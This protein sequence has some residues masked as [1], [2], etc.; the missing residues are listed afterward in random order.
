MRSAHT[1]CH[2]SLRHWVEC[3]APRPAIERAVANDAC[4][5]PT[6]CNRHLAAH[7]LQRYHRTAVG[8]HCTQGS[9]QRLG[10]EAFRVA[11]ALLL[12]VLTFAS[13][14]G[15]R[16]SEELV[17][18]RVGNRL[19]EAVLVVE[20]EGR[21]WLPLADVSSTLSVR[22]VSAQDRPLHLATPLGIV[23]VPARYLVQTGDVAYIDTHFLRDRLSAAVSLDPDDLLITVELPWRAGAPV[24]VAEDR[25]P[26]LRLEPEARPPRA[27]LSTLH[28]DLAYTFRKR[29]RNRFE[30]LFRASG[31]A[32]GGV[33]R[34][35]YE[36]DIY[37][38]RRLRD[39]VWMT[40]FGEGR[41]LQFGHQTIAQ[42][43]LMQTVELTGAQVAWTNV[44]A[45]L[46]NRSLYAGAL[47][48][49]TVE[50][51][52]TFEGRGPVGGFAQLWLNDQ[53]IAQTPIGIDGAYRFT[54]VILPV[55]QS[56]VQIR[57]Y[58]HRSAVTPVDIISK[59]L[60]LSD[61]LLQPGQMSVSG[62]VGHGRNTFEDLFDTWRRP[63]ESDAYRRYPGSTASGTAFARYAPRSGLTLE[64]GAS[65]VGGVTRGMVG[66]IA[67]LSQRAIAS[68]AGAAGAD[69]GAAYIAELDWRFDAWRFLAHSSWRR[70]HLGRRAGDSRYAVAD[71]DHTEDKRGRP[72]W[73][74]FAELGYRVSEQL[75][76]GVIARSVPEASF[77]IPFFAWRPWPELSVKA[78]PNKF[79]HYRVDGRYKLSRHAWIHSSYNRG[80]GALSFVHT[81]GGGL[82]LSTELQRTAIGTWR[83][84]LGASGPASD[85]WDLSWHIAGYIDQHRRHSVQ[86]SIN[87]TIR[88]GVQAYAQAYHRPLRSD[89][90]RAVRT[91][92]LGIRVGLRYDLAVSEAGFTAAPSHSIPLD[93][94]ALAG[95]IAAEHQAAEADLSGIP[96]L[97]DGRVATRT[98]PDGT[99]FVQD[100]KS[101]IHTVEMDDEQLPIEHVLEKRM[102]VA[103][104]AP[105]AVTPMRFSTHVEY[106]VAGK[107]STRADAPIA[108]ANI[109]IFDAAGNL[110]GEGTTNVFGYYRIDGLKRGTYQAKVVGQSGVPAA[111]RRFR[112]DDEYVF[113]ID[114]RLTGKAR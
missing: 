99:F 40:S 92:D 100:L 14:S 45:P 113:G 49:R 75:M 91:D 57:V 26:E 28:G 19:L 67:R 23:D 48:S 7:G 69:V 66:A 43:P 13:S 30:G 90:Y 55:R 37:T 51:R 89:I 84:G 72:Y 41:F 2:P 58:D 63:S 103:E 12:A 16:A 17:G 79:G 105:G 21:Y 62:A 102:I 11:A 106:G 52:R 1:S 93:R 112:I 77:I 64:A 87:K 110:M 8:I 15:V 98:R 53:L 34:V 38:R 85:G 68:V 32:Y 25:R 39:A 96:I 74:H 47:L 29:D 20:R 88:P 101:G 3:G 97:V 83:A 35:T 27:G 109:K 50:T 56:Q 95:R 76:V 61:L 44:P 114:F 71:W 82:S 6:E 86:G 24:L 65:T 33:W 54:D 108:N 104:V 73:D 59:S 31:H 107:L 46:N 60:N 70:Y 36:E 80:A 5:P 18:L 111:G 78:R 10:A 81:I 22:V 94:G 42:H 9:A 4:R